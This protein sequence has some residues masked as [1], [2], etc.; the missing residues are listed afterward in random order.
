VCGGGNCLPEDHIALYRACAI[1]KDYDKGVFT[2]QRGGDP[3]FEGIAAN[4]ADTASAAVRSMK[5]CARPSGAG[6]MPEAKVE[7]M[8]LAD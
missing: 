7:D 8:P 3:E 1:E 5:R 4:F 2:A 6:V